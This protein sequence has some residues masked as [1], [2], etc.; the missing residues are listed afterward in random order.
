MDQKKTLTQLVSTELDII[1]QLYDGGG[2]IT[3]EIAALMEITAENL[4]K[5]VDAYSYRMDR[6][7]M[8]VAFL[9]ARSDE[10]LQIVKRFQT[11]KDRMKDSIKFAM[12]S[13][14]VTELSGDDRRF[15]LSASAPRV[16]IFSENDLP[17]SFVREK[18][19]H[20]PDKDLIKEALK[21]GEEVPGARLLEVHS[22]R[23]YTAKKGE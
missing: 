8:E 7:D 23:T 15:K 9:K 2:E 11:M 20:E 12:E 1:R 19:I 6:L 17:G 14:Q 18:V 5:K 21:R 13:L 22:L 4:P 16:D 10:I 3:P